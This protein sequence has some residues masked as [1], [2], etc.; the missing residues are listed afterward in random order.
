MA[1]IITFADPAFMDFQHFTSTLFQR[2]RQPLPGRQAQL[3]MSSMRRIQ[4]LLNLGIPSHAHQSSVLLLLYPFQA[5]IGIVLILRPAYGGVHGGQISFPGGK[6][7]ESDHSPVDTALREA[8]E[9]IGID[10]AEIRVIGQL[11]NLYI[12][13]SNFLVTPV[14]ACTAEKPHFIADPAEVERIIEVSLHDLLDEGNVEKYRFKTGIGITLQA[15]CYHVSGIRIWGAT[16]M[17]L[18]EFLEVVRPLI[19]SAEESHA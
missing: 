11:T 5:F 14:V 18:S 8:S 19:R 2:L 1:L 12:P 9:E 4:E 7:E 15:P 6:R 13:P 10:S 3:K 17:M 16:A